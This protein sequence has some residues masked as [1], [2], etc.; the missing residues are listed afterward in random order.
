MGGGTA[1][2]ATDLC[3]DMERLHEERCKTHPCGY[4]KL[5][6]FGVPRDTL[7]LVASPMHPI[8]LPEGHELHQI[9]QPSDGGSEAGNES[10]PV[11][12]CAWIYNRW[13]E[14][15]FG[16]NQ[17]KKAGDTDEEEDDS[18]RRSFFSRRFTERRTTR[19]HTTK[20]SM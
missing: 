16:E 1:S 14:W 11:I 5:F 20:V 10:P 13:D 9:T 3:L 8:T 18:I 17:T 15:E 2:P 7:R 6:D 12:S 4:E 19:R